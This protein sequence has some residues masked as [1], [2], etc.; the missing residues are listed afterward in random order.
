MNSMKISPQK[1]AIMVVTDEKRAATWSLLEE[2]L[3]ETARDGMASTR[4]R[5]VAALALSDLHLREDLHMRDTL[6][7]IRET[8]GLL[9][10]SN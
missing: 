4:V 8:L 10:A 1:G 6:N 9:S 2:I 5:M 7:A 3:E